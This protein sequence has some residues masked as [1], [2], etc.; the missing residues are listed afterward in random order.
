MALW[1]L[2]HCDRRRCTGLRLLRRGLARG[3]RL[4]QRFPG[5]VLSP[6]AHRRLSPA[7]RQAVSRGGVAVIDC[8]W[9]RLQELPLDRM[10]GAHPRLL[11]HLVAANPVNYGRP[12]RL[13]CAEAW[14]AALAIAGFPERA[15]SLLDQ[16]KWGRAF[17]DLNRELLEKYAACSGEEEVLA[18]EQEFLAAEPRR[19]EEEIEKLPGVEILMKKRQRMKTMRIAAAAAQRTH[20]RHVQ[21]LWRS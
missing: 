10:R 13:S 12:C 21:L 19:E 17:L 16:F 14:A 3:L 8:S 11:P 9:A 20:M 4:G 5:V 18:V 2:G 15:A 6:A 7:D 1:D